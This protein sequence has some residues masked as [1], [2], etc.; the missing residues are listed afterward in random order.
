MTAPLTPCLWFDGNAEEAA[1]F[2]VSVFPDSRIDKV[3]R[4]AAQTPGNEKGDVITVDFTIR[5]QRF[6]GLNGGPD[7][8]FNEAVSFMVDCDDQAEVDRYWDALV[9]GGGEHGP[10]GWLK[11]RFGLSW[12]VT[13]KRLYE[14]LDG[15]DAAGAERAMQ[16]MLAMSKLDV[17]ELEAAYRGEVEPAAAR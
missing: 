14:L 10:C 11:D 2:Y 9:A 4:A 15:P 5:G 12:Q 7:F 8:R 3:S 1:E 17:A 13:P 6:V 16:A